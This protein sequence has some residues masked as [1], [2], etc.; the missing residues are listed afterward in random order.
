MLKADLH[1]HCKGDPE[2]RFIKHTAKEYIDHA[3]KLGFNIISFTNHTSVFDIAPFKEYAWKKGVILIPGAEA[4]I[5]GK[6]ILLYNFTQ[7]QVNSIKTFEDLRRIKSKK[8]LVIAPHPFYPHRSPPR[9]KNRSLGRLLLE[10]IDLFDGIEYCNFYTKYFG[11]N[12]KAVLTAKKHNLSLIG[13]SDAHARHEMNTTYSLIHTKKNTVASIIK[14]IKQRQVEVVSNPRH[15]RA[16]L[17]IVLE[18]A[19]HLKFRQKNL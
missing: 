12:K 16:I 1:T 15:T 14:A 4:K 19:K 5:K 2:D 8:H 10:N 7:Q 9:F 17:K 3:A 11:F 13:T 6:D 18:H